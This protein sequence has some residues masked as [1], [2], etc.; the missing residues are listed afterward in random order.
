MFLKTILDRVTLMTSVARKKDLLHR[1]KSFA[2]LRM[3]GYALL[4]IPF[5]LSAATDGIAAIVN[6]E[7]ITRSA[8]RQRIEILQRGLLAQGAT[9]PAHRMLAKQAL[10]ALILHT[11]L[12]QRAHDRGIQVEEWELQAALKEI[13][14]NNQLSL[15]ALEQALNQEGLTLERFRTQLREQIT[16]QKLQA[17]ELNTELVVKPEEVA[18]YMKQYRPQLIIDRFR[19]AHILIPCNIEDPA[20]CARAKK[21]SETLFAKI[22]AGEN[23]AQLAKTYS[24]AETA[25]DGGDLGFRALEDLPSVFTPIVPKL[26]PGTVHKPILGQGG[27]HIVKLIASEASQR[28]TKLTETVAMQR[29]REEK[30]QQALPRFENTIR[31]EAYIEIL[32]EAP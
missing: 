10:D 25:V 29:L 7:I 17:V 15:A 8:W 19:I 16:I 3:T 24:G 13:Q 27:Y 22:Q 14:N 30:L 20:D 12:L 23:F 18:R 32:A 11:L 26:K 5:A 31:S 21:E 9:L 28:E 2:F 6:N 1:R 4:F